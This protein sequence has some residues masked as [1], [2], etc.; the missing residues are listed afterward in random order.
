[1]LIPE[2][3]A[4]LVNKVECSCR[5][6]FKNPNFTVDTFESCG[7]ADHDLDSML[8]SVGERVTGTIRAYVVR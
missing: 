1:M 8:M 3:G 6:T 2:G 7:R 5:A 4:L